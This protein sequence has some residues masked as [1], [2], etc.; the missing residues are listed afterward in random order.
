MKKGLGIVLVS[1]LIVV[2]IVALADDSGNMGLWSVQAYIDE[3]NMPTDDYYIVSNAIQGTFSNTVVNNETLTAYIFYGVNGEIWFR[4]F[5]YDE[6]AVNNVFSATTD[7]DIVMMDTNGERHYYTGHLYPKTQNILL[8]SDNHYPTAKG[9]G[10][11]TTD[12]LD[13]YNMLKLHPGTFRFAI[14]QKDNPLIKYVFSIEDTSGF[15]EVLNELYGKPYEKYG[16]HVG[17]KIKH[18]TYGEG[19]IWGF[20]SLDG[21]IM[22]Q[23]EVSPDNLQVFPL[24]KE[25]NNIK[26]LD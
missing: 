19:V 4:L 3:F 1:L 24:E 5:E 16:I 25:L 2:S 22:L 10:L 17:T 14:T 7:Y 21:T 12:A 11:Y 6:Y 20:T 26:I 13:L 15:K 18:N 23:M 9:S 8:D